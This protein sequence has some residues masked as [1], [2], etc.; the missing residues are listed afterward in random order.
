MLLHGYLSMK[1]TFIRQI[2][3]FAPKMRVIAIDMRGFGKSEPLKTPYSLDDYCQDVYDF[4]TATGVKKYSIVGHSFGGRVAVKLALSD[5]R[6]DNLILVGAAGIKPK[7]KPAYYFKVLKYKFLKR[8]KKNFNADKYGSDDYKK[9]DPVMKQS[10]VKIVNE[11]LNGVICGIKNRTLIIS[12]D[13]DTETPPYFA[14]TFNKKIKGSELY[15]VKGGGHFCFLKNY[16]EV[17]A[18]LNEFLKGV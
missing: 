16:G 9:L 5:K 7:R 18:V 8:F 14:K 15:F 13:K 1:E 11:H 17:N 2:E 12:G 6:V 4:L 3:Y 10:F